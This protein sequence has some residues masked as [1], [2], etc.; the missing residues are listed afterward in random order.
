MLMLYMVLVGFILE[1]GSV[2]YSGMARTHMLRIAH[3]RNK[4]SSEKH[5][6]DSKQ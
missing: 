5:V 6:F 4:D 2:R 3:M 1:C